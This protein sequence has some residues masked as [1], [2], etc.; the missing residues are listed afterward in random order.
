MSSLFDPGS[1]VT[2]GCVVPGYLCGTHE[3]CEGPGVG[4]GNPGKVQDS[5]TA[6][7]QIDHLEYSISFTNAVSDISE[8]TK[9]IK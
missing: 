4:S 1:S 7:S 5:G 3:G 6:F 8:L 2:P 9:L